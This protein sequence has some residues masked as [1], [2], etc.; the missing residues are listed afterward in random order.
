MALSAHWTPATPRSCQATVTP[1]NAQSVT[2]SMTFGLKMFAGRMDG[3]QHGKPQPK[4][5]NRK[6]RKD[7]KEATS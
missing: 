4:L 6:E 1:E 3:G 2:G 7:H 5:N